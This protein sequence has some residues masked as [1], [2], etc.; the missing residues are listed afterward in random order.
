MNSYFTTIGENLINSLP[1]PSE[2]AV[3]DG[4]TTS[5]LIPA[6][7]FSLLTNQV[8]EEKVNKLKANKSSGPDVVSPKLLK[9]AGKAI[10]PALTDIFN[11]S[12]NCRTVF[13]SW[14][15]ARLTPIFK[16]DDET[17]RGNYRPVSLLSVPSKILE[18]VVNDRLVHHVFRD[19]Q[20]ITERQ[21]A[22]QRGYSTELLLVHLVEIWRSAVDSGRV[23]AVTFVDFRKAF[24]S[25]CHEILVKKLEYRFG[26]SGPLLDWIKDYL[27]GRM[28]FTVL[29]G[30][31]SDILPIITGIPQGSVLGSTLFTLF[32]NDL[33][34]TISEGDLYMYA[35]D[36]SI[37]CIGENADVAVVALNN[38]LLEVQ[39]WCIENRLTPYPTK[40][41]A[42]VLSRQTI[43]RPL[44]PFLLGSSVLN[45]VTKSR[46]LGTSVDDQLSWIPH[47]LELKKNFSN[48]LDLLKRSRFLP[49]KVLLR[50]YFSVI[51]PSVKYGIVLWG[52][53][54]NSDLVKSVNSLHCRAARIIFNL[55]RDVP[56]TEV[57]TRAQWQIMSLHYKIDILK[58]FHKGYNDE[59]PA[60]LSESIYTRR[61]NTFSLRGKD[62]L[63]VPRFETRY[64]KDSLAHRGSVLRHMVTFKEHDIPHLSK[65]DL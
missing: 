63:V 32:T 54:T 65:N 58:I 25:V 9:L 22:Y 3:V 24:D 1:M 5:C 18:A 46:L 31:K 42:M 64:L 37:Y 43:T 2:H 47:M 34:A 50:F 48:K 27:S 6:P 53:C 14:Q 59:L 44:P 8:V 45:Y 13:S 40:S 39:R 21:W 11:Y 35:N 62:S 41:E 49:R 33:P 60:L 20:F 52:S 4:N 55:P 12:I 56:L 61:R 10:V 30:V 7:S 15:T 28:Q 51:L 29:N 17:D 38:T 23:V 26:V 19:N 16:K 57:L 36:T